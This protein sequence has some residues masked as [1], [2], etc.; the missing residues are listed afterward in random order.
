M[1]E[2]G[3]QLPSSMS[4]YVYDLNPYALVYTEH[5]KLS[6]CIGCCLQHIDRPTCSV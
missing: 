5:E 6:M 3:V 2:S 1:I 4:D